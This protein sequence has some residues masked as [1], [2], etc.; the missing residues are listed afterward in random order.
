MQDKLTKEDVGREEKLRRTKK[1][2]GTVQQ[3]Q[4]SQVWRTGSAGRMSHWLQSVN[5]PADPLQHT[6]AESWRP[7][8]IHKTQQNQK[9]KKGKSEDKG[10]RGQEEGQKVAIKIKNETQWERS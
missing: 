7:A 6:P 10:G 3:Q 4:Q 5:E 8:A 1:K 9:L 2:D